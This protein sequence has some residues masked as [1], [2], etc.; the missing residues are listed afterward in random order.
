[1]GIDDANEFAKIFGVISVVLI[2]SG[3]A[4]LIVR[5]FH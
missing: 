1:M 3:N 4:V 2:T 5:P